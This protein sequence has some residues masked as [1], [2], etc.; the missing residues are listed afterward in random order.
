MI[1]QF[2]FC[3]NEPIFSACVYAKTL[4]LRKALGQNKGCLSIEDS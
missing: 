1:T 4:T 2:C 3:F